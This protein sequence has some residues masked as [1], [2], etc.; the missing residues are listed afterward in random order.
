MK[1]KKTVVALACALALA[2]PCAAFAAGA[3]AGGDAKQE[4]DGA[5]AQA[6]EEMGPSD[7]L[8]AWAQDNDCAS[9]HVDE[10]ASFEAAEEEVDEDE[11]KEDEGE[12][13]VAPAELHAPFKLACIDCHADDVLIERHEGVTEESKTP[14]RLKK[15]EVPLASCETCHP[16]KVLVKATAE[17]TALTDADGTVVNPHDVPAIKEHEEIVCDSC[18]KMHKDTSPKNRA[19]ELCVGCHHDDVYECYTCHA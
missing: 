7:E 6:A 4:T 18:H 11:A 14:T 16:A 3:S 9:C 8:L 13:K 17:S 1:S 15:S 12:K 5:K 19:A 2:L 10:A